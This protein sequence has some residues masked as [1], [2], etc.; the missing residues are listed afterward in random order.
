MCSV[1][2]CPWGRW[3]PFQA[4]LAAWLE[5]AN[6]ELRPHGVFVKGVT[7]Q[8]IDKRRTLRPRNACSQLFL[9]D[10]PTLVLA[11]TPDAAARLGAARTVQTDCCGFCPAIAGRTL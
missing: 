2:C 9:Q 6:R 4:A 8:D 1:G 5:D 11:T 7:F 3:D 10:L